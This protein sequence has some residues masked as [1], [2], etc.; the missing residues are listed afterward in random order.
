METVGGCDGHEPEPRGAA[1]FPSMSVDPRRFGRSRVVRSRP[2]R[3]AALAGRYAGHPEAVSE[4]AQLTH[5]EILTPRLAATVAFFQDILG[6]DV[7]CVLGQSAY[8][9]AYEDPYHS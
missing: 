6:L 2:S 7:T 4:V 1:G 8:L 3:R 9:R 5:V